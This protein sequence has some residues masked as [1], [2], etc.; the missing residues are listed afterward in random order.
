MLL[1]L[2]PFGLILGAQAVHQGMTPFTITLM[3]GT[4]FAGGSEFAAVDLWRSPLPIFSI[5]LM[6]FMVNSRHILMGATFAPYIHH[7]PLYQ[8]IPILMFM[9]DESW[10]MGL[11]DSKKQEALL[12]VPYYWGVALSLYLMWV[13]CGYIGATIG[14]HLEN[15]DRFGFGLALPAV[16]IVLIRGMYR[17]RRKALPWLASFF[18]AILTY[19]FIPINGLYV[20][21]GTACGLATAYYSHSE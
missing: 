1:G 8:K 2:M 7:L 10:S 5:I 17:G 15:I 21:V 9:T 6:T 12:N 16:F 18:G 14:Q 13:C 20:I 19:L 3:M 4:N 11:A